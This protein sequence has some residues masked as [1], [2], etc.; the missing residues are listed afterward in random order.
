M[1][2]LDRSGKDHELGF[3]WDTRLHGAALS[4]FIDDQLVAFIPSGFSG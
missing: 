1:H 3:G 4:I 2:V